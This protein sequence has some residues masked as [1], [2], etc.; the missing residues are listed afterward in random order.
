MYEWPTVVFVTTESGQ[1]ATPDIPDIPP[2]GRD[3]LI[4][5]FRVTRTP[6]GLFLAFSTYRITAIRAIYGL[7]GV[8]VA[9]DLQELEVL[10]C[11]ERIKRSQ[12]DAATEKYA[13]DPAA[14]RAA[15][16]RLY[17]AVFRSPDRPTR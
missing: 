11:A 17:G 8:V 1:A 4:P 10:C 16:V 2:E 13:D 12:I 14:E 3:D 7:K 5:E 15:A 9:P 6:D